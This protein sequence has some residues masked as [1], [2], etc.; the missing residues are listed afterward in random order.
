MNRRFTES[1]KM[2]LSAKALQVCSYLDENGIVYGTVTHSPAFT[3][4]ECHKINEMIGGTICKNLLLK[5][6]SGKVTVLLMIKDGKRFVTKDVSKKLGCS[7]LSFASGEYMEAL[8]NTSP[9]SLSITSLIFDREKKVS[10][11]I[12]KDVIGEEYICCH[13]SD[14]TATLKIKTADVLEKLLPSLG[15]DATVIEI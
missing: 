4:E 1:D 8:L 3:L 6:D 10:L 7:R 2:E 11:A 15:I 12:D 5:T 9:G 13:P 14:N